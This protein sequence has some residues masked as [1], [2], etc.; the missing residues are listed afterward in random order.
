MALVDVKF[1]GERILYE[2]SLQDAQAGYSGDRS[3]QFFYSDASWSLSMLSASLEPGVDCPEGAHYLSAVDWYHMRPGGDAE[4]DP[5]NPVEEFYPICV[6][7]WE[8]DHT[9]WRHMQ[10]SDPPEVRGL[11]RKTLIVRSMCTV[12]NYDY[13]VDVKLREDGEI[14]VHTLFAGYIESRYYDPNF[15]PEEANF[16]TPLRPG[17]AGP[18]H[19]HGVAWKADFDIW[20]VR[21]NIFKVT[22]VKSGAIGLTAGNGQPLV[23]KY[24]EHRYVEQEGI[25]V[26]TFISDPTRPA[27]WIVADRTAT[28]EAGNPRGYAVTLSDFSTV[29]VLPDDHPFVRAMPY[30]KYQLA[31]TKYHDE[32]Y[33]VTS[34]YIHYDGEETVKNTQDLERFLSDGESLVDED[35]V[36]WI[37]V[38]KEHIV[39]QEDMPLVSNFGVGFSLKPWNFFEQNIAASPL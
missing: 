10:N 15:N 16:S 20:G 38:G 6:F 2:L 22:S 31:L 23:S 18:V 35:L 39:R 9:I 37:G 32:E 28:S 7:E 25:G 26:S 34:P 14:D 1:N 29:Q 12:A 27:T 36:T 4:S 24:L 5:T 21:E 19:S 3:S 17:L 11:T 30:T 8:E 13:I 33:R